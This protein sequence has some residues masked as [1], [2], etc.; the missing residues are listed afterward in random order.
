[1]TAPLELGDYLVRVS[2]PHCDRAAEVPAVIERVLKVKGSEGSLT[3]SVSA[4]PVPHDCNQLTLDEQMV[5]IDLATGQIVG[6]SDE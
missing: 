5:G 3:V 6:V 2:C 1:V 4:K